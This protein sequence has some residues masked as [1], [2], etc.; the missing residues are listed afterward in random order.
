MTSIRN[1]EM[2]KALSSHPHVTIEKV[3]FSL[4]QRAIYQ[5]THSIIGVHIQD[6]TSEMGEKWEKILNTPN[7]QLI[8]VIMQ[9]GEI[10]KADIS[11]IRLETCISRD[12]K[13]LGIQLFRFVDFQY[14]PITEVR[15][16]EGELVKLFEGL[17]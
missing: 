14:H 3:F 8:E 16:F 12:R 7:D 5:P 13:F 9:V 6:Y 11:N 2:A 15:F 1:L 17:L 10:Q 4:I